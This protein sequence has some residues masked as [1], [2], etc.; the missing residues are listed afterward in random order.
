MVTEMSRILIFAGTSEGHE[1]ARFLM[2][3]G[4]ASRTDI[5][6]ATDYGKVVLDDIEDMCILTGRLDE[7]AMENLIDNGDYCLIVDATHPY[8]AEV[9]ACILEAALKTDTE[10]IRLV[11]DEET[12]EGLVTVSTV[13][14]AAELLSQSNEG[15]LLTTGAKE[16]KAFSQ[17]RNFSER[18]VARV[19]PSEMSLTACLDAGLPP[20]GIICMQGPF[21]R[22]MNMATMKQYGLETL[23]TKSTGRA[24]GFM[25]KAV[26]ADDGYRII[27]IGRPDDESGYTLEEVKERLRTL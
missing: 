25:N 6:V 3:E 1:L 2:N 17:V 20:K 9:T 26:L 21:T 11:R 16:L 22:E 13:N 12:A 15:F 7:P 19:L 14:E 10:V 5:C 24:G 4:M 27:V 23:V 18:A 8:A